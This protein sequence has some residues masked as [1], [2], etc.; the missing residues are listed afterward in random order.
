MPRNY[1]MGY[2]DFP[3]E[4]SR[5]RRPGVRA[6]GGTRPEWERADAQRLAMRQE[7]MNRMAKGG[8]VK[9]KHGGPAIDTYDYD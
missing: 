9:L 1:G 3:A 2:G 7:G 6:E 8:T 4:S 5:E